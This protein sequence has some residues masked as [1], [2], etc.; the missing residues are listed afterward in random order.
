MRRRRDREFADLDELWEE[1][2]A[3][4]KRG[5]EAT[6]RSLVRGRSTFDELTNRMIRDGKIVIRD[7]VE[8]VRDPAD[9]GPTMARDPRVFEPPDLGK[10]RKVSG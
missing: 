6:K 7:V 9:R 2:R 1:L 8:I 4:R 5:P 3:A 10:L